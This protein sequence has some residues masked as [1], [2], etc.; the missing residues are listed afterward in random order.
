VRITIRN[1]GGTPTNIDKVFF[2]N[3]QAWPTSAG[4]QALAGR[5]E[6]ESIFVT[7]SI[8]QELG[9]S[10]K[11]YAQDIAGRRSPNVDIPPALLARLR[12]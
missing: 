8:R 2:D 12:A 1:N 6:V 10:T 4:F 9:G 7:S 5:S 3:G 11:A